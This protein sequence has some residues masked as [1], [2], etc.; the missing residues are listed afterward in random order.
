M[1]VAIQASFAIA[2][3]GAIIIS[4]LFYYHRQTPAVWVTFATIMALTLGVC[5]YWQ[6]KIWE[7][8][9]PIKANEQIPATPET[10]HDFFK[11]DFNNLLKASQ[12]FK[13]V[14]KDK[15]K[16]SINFEAQIYAD[17]DSQS[18]FLG[19]YIPQ[20]SHTYKICEALRDYKNILAELQT[21]QVAVEAR[22]QGDRPVELKDL[23]FSGRVF[24]Y[25]EYPLFASQIDELT[26]L[27]KSNN[28]FPQFRGVDYVYARKN[29]LKQKL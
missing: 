1:Q 26:A 21:K 13:L 24:V 9:N 11:T 20:S 10:L 5:L 7:T 16:E 8:P 12:S 6:D 2:A 15:D 28:L 22:S 19:F 14:L 25:H 23:K 29:P 4:I 27:Y 17:F 3:A 18:I